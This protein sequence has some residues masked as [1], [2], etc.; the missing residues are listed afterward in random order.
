MQKLEKFIPQQKALADFGN[1]DSSRAIVERAVVENSWFTPRDVT[2]S[3]RAIA[4]DMLS[5]RALE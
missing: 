3:L 1:N 2:S 5:P 4:A